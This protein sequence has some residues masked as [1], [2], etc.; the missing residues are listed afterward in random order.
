M[1]SAVSTE[2]PP[3][4]NQPASLSDRH[5]GPSLKDYL[6]AFLQ[7]LIVLNHKQLKRPLTSSGLLSLSPLAD[8]VGLDP[9]ERLIRVSSNVN[10]VLFS[11]NFLLASASIFRWFSDDAELTALLW[12]KPCCIG[13]WQRPVHLG[14]YQVGKVS[15]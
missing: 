12:T 1:L 3:A 10:I 15:A 4:T 11:S 2:G 8:R 6:E 7:I 9:S 13:F 14:I 5:A